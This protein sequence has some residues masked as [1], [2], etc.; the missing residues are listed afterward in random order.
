MES[1]KTA[2]T[3]LE[4]PCAESGAEENAECVVEAGFSVNVPRRRKIADG[5]SLESLRGNVRTRNP[6]DDIEGN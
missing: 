1:P 4:A 3:S 2:V 5:F 6:K